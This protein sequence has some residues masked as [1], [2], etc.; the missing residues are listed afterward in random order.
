MEMT[1]LQLYDEQDHFNN[2]ENGCKYDN[3]YL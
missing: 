2:F 3:L 1:L